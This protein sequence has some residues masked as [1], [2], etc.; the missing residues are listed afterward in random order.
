MRHLFESRGQSIGV[1]ASTSVLPMNYLGLISFRIDWFNLFA[2]Q[3]TLKN[4]LLLLLLSCFR[5]VRL[6]A[7]PETAA[8][9]AP[10]S[11]GFCRQ[12]HWSGL[13][14]PS[15]CMKVKNVSEI[16]QLCPSFCN[17]MDCSLPGSSIHGIFHT[18]VLEWGKVL[19]KSD[20]TREKIK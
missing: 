8:H 10:Q 3:G 1:L 17:P 18:R 15:P 6:C 19:F 13:P 7:T 9:H 11:L 20:I 14:P 16:T 5:R 4:Q 2:V 12:E